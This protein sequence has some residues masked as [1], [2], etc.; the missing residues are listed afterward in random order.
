M[1]S[2]PFGWVSVCFSSS[3]SLY[4]YP[5]VFK[6][7]LLAL[8]GES[9]LQC[10]GHPLKRVPMIYIFHWLTFCGNGSGDCRLILWENLFFLRLS[11]HVLTW[12]MGNISIITV[13]PTL[14]LGLGS[15][16][17]VLMKKHWIIFSEQCPKWVN[18]LR[19]L[20]GFEDEQ[21]KSK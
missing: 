4:T 14:E 5:L 3:L 2:S 12:V 15:D 10:G 21:L 7:S 19:E 11:C 16:L 13:K 20:E 6:A 9:L 18:V 1:G 17:L 8:K